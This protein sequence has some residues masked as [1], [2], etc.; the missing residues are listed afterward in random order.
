MSNIA[1]PICKTPW[2]KKVSQSE[3]NPNRVYNTCD[4]CFLEKPG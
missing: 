2:T 4:N 1:C 3:K